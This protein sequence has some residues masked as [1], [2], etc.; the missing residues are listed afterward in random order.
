MLNL[1]F[2]VEPWGFL[3]LFLYS[4]V[5]DSPGEEEI[6]EFQVHPDWFEMGI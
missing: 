6:P 4:D 3:A 1:W 5:C 2:I